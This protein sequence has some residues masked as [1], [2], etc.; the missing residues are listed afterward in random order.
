MQIK[1]IKGTAYSKREDEFRNRNKSN[2]YMNQREETCKDY[3]ENM[4]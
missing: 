2:K 4:A 1:Y 3:P